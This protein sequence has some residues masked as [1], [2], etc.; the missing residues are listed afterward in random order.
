TDQQTCKWK[1]KGS[2]RSG[3]PSEKTTGKLSS[4]KKRALPLPPTHGRKTW[5]VAWVAEGQECPSSLAREAGN[6]EGGQRTI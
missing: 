5:V 2:G 6:R 1:I 4:G 3:Q